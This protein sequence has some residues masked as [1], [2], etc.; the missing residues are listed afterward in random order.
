MS[1]TL[2]VHPIDDQTLSVT[3]AGRLDVLGVDAVET[4]F[5]AAIVPSGRSAV[6]D[7]AGVEF[8]ASLGIR[9]FVSVGR[10][11][12]RDG[13]AMALH[14]CSD[15]VAEVLEMAALDQL[16]VVAPDAASARAALKG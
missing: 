8:V 12:A 14:S 1:A 10:S 11:L 15:A 2:Q 13:R 9:M 5:T 3:L 4:K 6:I 7:M 16:M